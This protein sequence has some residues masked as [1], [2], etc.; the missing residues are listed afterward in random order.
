MVKVNQN[1]YM[2]N[3]Y[4]LKEKTSIFILSCYMS[5]NYRSTQHARIAWRSGCIPHL[6]LEI[7]EGR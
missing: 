7:G 3:K 1:M 5:T 2:E 4:V 6:L